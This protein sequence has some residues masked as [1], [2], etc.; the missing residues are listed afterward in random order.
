M[1]RSLSAV[2]WSAYARV[3]DLM[4]ENNPAYQEILSTCVAT[5]K[6]WNLAAGSRLIDLGGGTGNFSVRL[7]QSLPH[8]K[9]VHVDRNPAMQA[10]AVKK[11]RRAGL[12]NHHVL[13]AEA[14]RIN[15]PLKSVAGIVSVHALNFVKVPK[16]MIQKLSGWLAPK[17][18]LFACD[19]GRHMNMTDWAVYLFREAWQ[20]H[21]LRKAMELFWEGRAVAQQNRQLSREYDQ[22]LF[23]IHNLA[24]YRNTFKRCGLAIDQSFLCYRGYS[25]AVVAHKLR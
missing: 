10:I 17:G 18:H 19:I 23:W 16:T 8:C 11:A 12:R 2:N 15:F 21:G 3:Y 7:A 24:G 22:G 5:V 9:I 13:L 14:E 25:N 6:S 20:R 1:N 4:A